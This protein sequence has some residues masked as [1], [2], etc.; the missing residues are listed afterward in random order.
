[1]KAEHMGLYFIVS[2]KKL[3]NHSS[4]YLVISPDILDATSGS[5]PA[6]MWIKLKRSGRRTGHPFR[7]LRKLDLQA[8]MLDLADDLV[9]ITTPLS[10]PSKTTSSQHIDYIKM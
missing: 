8:F 1:M 3:P 4:K 10:T 6:G 7:L 9:T 2:Y 5:S